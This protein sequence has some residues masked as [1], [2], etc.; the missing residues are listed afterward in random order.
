MSN[1]FSY[2]KYIR[3]NKKHLKMNTDKKCIK[4]LKNHPG[5]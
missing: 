2:K 1:I 5:F 3:K 4:P